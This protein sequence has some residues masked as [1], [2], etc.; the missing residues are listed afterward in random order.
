MDGEDLGGLEEERPQTGM[1]RTLFLTH[2]FALLFLQSI[3]SGDK[4]YF[5]PPL[6]PLP[7]E[8]QHFRPK[9]DDSEGIRGIGGLANR[10]NRRRSNKLA[11]LSLQGDLRRETPLGPKA[12]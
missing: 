5:L 3:K 1:E 4:Q 11:P 12:E 2:P 8:Q 7:I 9:M 10:T 6:M